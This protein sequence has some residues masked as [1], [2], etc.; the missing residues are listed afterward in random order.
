MSPTVPPGGTASRLPAVHLDAIDRRILDLLSADGRAS[1]REVAERA[2]IGRA[3]AY[4]RIQRLQDEGVI[5]GFTVVLDPRRAGAGLAAYVYV[6]IDQH[7]WRT[8]GHLVA[9]L[10]GV[11]HVALVSGEFDLL[12]LVR[13]HDPSDLRD[14]VLEQLHAIDGVAATQTTFVLDEMNG[15]GYVFSEDAG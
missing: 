11:E 10:P 9:Q 6:K 12:L 2:R 4:S 15:A 8:L 7:A 3:T 13:V 14:V 1:V 5:G